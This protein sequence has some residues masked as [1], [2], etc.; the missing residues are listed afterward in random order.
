MS[1]FQAVVSIRCQFRK[2]ERG[3]KQ[4]NDHSWKGPEHC[5]ATPK[6]IHNLKGDEGEDKV[7]DG[8]KAAN[9]RRVVEA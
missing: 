8:Y 5:S 9:G 7:D 2:E 3:E 4:G 1:M 6:G